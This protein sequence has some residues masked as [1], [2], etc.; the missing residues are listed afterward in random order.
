VAE[1]AGL[2]NAP[3][4]TAEP[5]PTS[6]RAGPIV[7]STPLARTRRAAAGGDDPVA[8]RPLPSTHR[9]LLDRSTDLAATR[10]R[11]TSTPVAG[12][13]RAAAGGD[14]PVVARPVPSTH[15]SLLDRST[16]LAATRIR[17]TSASVP[18]VI[19]RSGPAVIQRR[20]GA[21]QSHR[22]VK[23]KSDVRFLANEDAKT[24]HYSLQPLA[25]GTPV[26]GVGADDDEYELADP[27]TDEQV[28]SAV[29]A[30]G[31]HDVLEWLAGVHR[32]LEKERF[33]DAVTLLKRM[34][35]IVAAM[36]QG[37][38][39]AMSENELELELG[40]LTY[41]KAL[42]RSYRALLLQPEAV[43]IPGLE[44]AIGNALPALTAH[45]FSKTPKEALA[46]SLAGELRARRR[47]PDMVPTLVRLLSSDLA[48]AQLAERR[49][50]VTRYEGEQIPV[51]AETS[52]KAAYVAMAEDK[53]AHEDKDGKYAKAIKLEVDKGILKEADLCSRAALIHHL[54]GPLKGTTEEI[55]KKLTAQ[56]VDSLL[57]E[58]LQKKS[59]RI[60]HL[61]FDRPALMQDV[62]KLVTDGTVHESIKALR[63]G[64]EHSIKDI[65]FYVG[66]KLNEPMLRWVV[67]NNIPVEVHA[68]TVLAS[69]AKLKA[70]G[71]TDIV[72]IPSSHE[73]TA[74]YIVSNP[75]DKTTKIVFQTRPGVSYAIA[76]IGAFLLYELHKIGAEVTKALSVDDGDWKHGSYQA[77]NVIK[78]DKTGKVATYLLANASGETLAAEVPYIDKPYPVNDDGTIKVAGIPTKT[79]TIKELK[80]D[81]LDE[82]N[83]KVFKEDVDYKAMY[84]N[85]LKGHHVD[86]ADLAIIGRK[87]EVKKML[88]VDFKAKKPALEIS[89]PGFNADL[90]LLKGSLGAKRVLL[91]QISPDFYGDRAKFLAQALE[92]IGVLH[93]AFVGTAGGIASGM[94]KFD[95][96][97]PEMITNIADYP[98]GTDKAK[99][100]SNQMANAALEV[101]KA[102]ASSSP[103]VAAVHK[104]GLHVG[105]HAPITESQELI[106]WMRDTPVSSVDCEGG[107]IAEV[108]RTSPVSL[109]SMYFLS[110]I[111]G[112]HESIG[113]GGIAGG[114]SGATSS[115]T[116][117]TPAR[118]A[119]EQII[120]AVIEKI[121]GTSIATTQ[122]RLPTKFKQVL[123]EGKVEVLIPN[124]RGG[125]DTKLLE[126]TVGEP[127]V[128]KQGGV[129]GALQMFA[130]FVATKIPKAKTILTPEM[131]DEINDG[132]DEFGKLH[133]LR[134][135]VAVR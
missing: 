17:P 105:V 132:A 29:A 116:T 64:K 55:A 58:H 44:Q 91:H 69:F 90:Y 122:E 84:L 7:R 4:G 9:S 114:S 19:R 103:E 126:V 93:I 48:G 70:E 66:D 86:S 57:K 73:G 79:I 119:S 87:K 20:I 25:G 18:S 97:V 129:L 34:H 24:G 99:E 59:E 2:R 27:A 82:K 56:T 94:K 12:A 75:D 128:F 45:D 63:G 71:F 10:I 65:N 120:K 106:Q 53:L 112:T 89:V 42:K 8:A 113:Q 38:A 80:V 47:Q 41:G 92:A 123:K 1:T 130:E 124:G 118:A 76:T 52:T 35:G 46:R 26:Q 98:S 28:V 22:V 96:A 81:R 109:Y 78:D 102:L 108:L 30:T 77:R 127:K 110:D 6:R 16:D 85:A 62:E 33:A 43:M 15:G 54:I 72:E 121:V 32:A 95:T 111:P 83:L 67:D 68:T 135:H 117:T 3:P 36:P 131:L 115:T 11:R 133:G 50:A 88:E 125:H 60:K 40:K 51:M 101:T 74:K 134:L 5:A 39:S 23:D 31:A 21:G 104:G 107:F 37:A 49:H 13:R 14:D 100:K 61:F